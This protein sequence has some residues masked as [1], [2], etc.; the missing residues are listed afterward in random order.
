MNFSL[1]QFL[2]IVNSVFLRIRL[3]F[4]NGLFLINKC[5]FIRVFLIEILCELTFIISVYH[6]TSHGG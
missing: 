6:Q 2:N 1:I 5:G 3:Y 4:A